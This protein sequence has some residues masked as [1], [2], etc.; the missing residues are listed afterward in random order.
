MGRVI[1]IDSRIPQ[2]YNWVELIPEN[3][4]EPLQYSFCSNGL[5]VNTYLEDAHEKLSVFEITD[6]RQ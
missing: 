3:T 5:I 6:P 1:M 2:V 4:R